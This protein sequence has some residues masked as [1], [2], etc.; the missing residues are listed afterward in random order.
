MFG[1]I[2]DPFKKISDSAH[3]DMQLLL[4]PSLPSYFEFA[5]RETSRLI[6]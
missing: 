1:I 3:D 2:F 5:K 4:E 6:L